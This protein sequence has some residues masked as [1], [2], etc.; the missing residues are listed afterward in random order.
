MAGIEQFFKSHSAYS[1]SFKETS[2]DKEKD[3]YLC[4]D[5]TQ[6]VINFD[7]II[8]DKYPDSHSY[9]PK[10]FDALYQLNSDIYLIEFKNQKPKFLSAHKQELEQKLLDGKNELDQL[11]AGLNIPKSAYNFKYCVIY[12]KCSTSHFN[13]YK[14]GIDKNII[15]FNLTKHKGSVVDDIKTNQVD[16]FTKLLNKKLTPSTLQCEG[17]I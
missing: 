8:E 9:R 15:K 16:F 12:Q 3:I 2:F 14:C 13:E 6:D 17:E 11:L 10:S 4:T 7:K 5:T 1:S